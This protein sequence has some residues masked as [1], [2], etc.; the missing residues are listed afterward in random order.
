MVVICCLHLNGRGGRNLWLSLWVVGLKMLK[1]F[2]ARQM[3]EP[4][5][6]V[7]HIVVFS[8]DSSEGRVH[9]ILVGDQ[10]NISQYGVYY[11]F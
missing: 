10:C 7:H 1:E 11:G 4:V 2:P 9:L 3:C 6:G 8:L 5:H